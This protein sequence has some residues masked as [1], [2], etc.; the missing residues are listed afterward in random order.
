MEIYL[1]NNI[2][3]KFLIFVLQTSTINIIEILLLDHNPLVT[4]NT[5][6]FIGKLSVFGQRRLVGFSHETA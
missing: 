2:S 3:S 5:Y 1:N 4:S 6:I